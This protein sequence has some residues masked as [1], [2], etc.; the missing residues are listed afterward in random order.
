M[1]PLLSPCPFADYTP[2]SYHRY[3]KSL[4]IEPPAKPI[5][6]EFSVRLNEKGNPVITVRRDPKVLSREEVE[7]IAAHLGKPL[8]EIW[9]LVRKRKIAITVPEP[10]RRRRG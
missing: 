7:Q 5:P 10:K 1:I 3:V 6:A 9:L 2:E 4:Y 8:Q